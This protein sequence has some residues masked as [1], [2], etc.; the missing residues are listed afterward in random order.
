M[1]KFLGAGFLLIAVLSASAQEIRV[2]T[3]NIFFLDETIIAERKQH[4]Q[5]VMRALNADVIGF[6]EINSPAGLRNILPEN[7]EV[8]M[9]DDPDETQEL[10]LA[11]RPPLK[12]T[13]FRAVFP[14]TVHDDAFPGGRDLLQ[15]N[16]SGHG[17]DFVFLVH[18]AKSRYGGRIET[19]FQRIA[20]SKLIMDHIK[21][22]LQNQNVVVMGDFNDNP[23]DRSLNI[24]EFGDANASGGIDSRDDTFLFN[25]TENLLD[26]NYCSYGYNYLFD[27]IARSDTFNLMIEGSRAENNKWRDQP[28]DFMK[29]VKIKTILYDQILVS[30]NLKAKVIGM[31]VFNR[32]VAIAGKSSRIEM[33]DGKLRYTERHD[34]ASDHVPVWAILNLN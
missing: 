33:I 15:V 32:T 4:L 3:Y 1:Q 25:T 9:L 18:H 5:E 17:N 27:T 24:L 16:V 8:A 6:Q 2:A 26:K 34:L 28:H 29:D 12:I 14:D 23:D 10:G 21:S 19:D 22:K 31:G 20:A 13:S 11:V 7:Y 30:L